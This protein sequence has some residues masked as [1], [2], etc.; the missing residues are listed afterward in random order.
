VIISDDSV[1]SSTASTE[2]EQKPGIGETITITKSPIHK[3]TI[4]ISSTENKAHVTRPGT[5]LYDFIPC[6]IYD[7]CEFFLSTLS[8]YMQYCDGL[9]S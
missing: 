6:H 1:P 3:G 9:I 4:T 2:A 7:H 5:L 8:L